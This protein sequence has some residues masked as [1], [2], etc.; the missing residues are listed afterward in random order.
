MQ[1]L[2]ARIASEL[3]LQGPWNKHERDILLHCLELLLH[4]GCQKLAAWLPLPLWPPPRHTC[5][6]LFDDVAQTLCTEGNYTPSAIEVRVCGPSPKLRCPSMARASRSISP[7]GT[8]RNHAF[9]ENGIEKARCEIFQFLWEETI[10]DDQKTAR[11]KAPPPQPPIKPWIETC[12]WLNH[13]SIH[14][15]IH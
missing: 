15:S 2:R 13:V 10:V 9:L 8:I 11:P 14:V 1:F 7:K 4:L 5:L 12:A 3:L 6:E